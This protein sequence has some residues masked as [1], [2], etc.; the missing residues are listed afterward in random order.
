MYMTT[1]VTSFINVYKNNSD[2]DEEERT[3]AFRMEKLMDL[4]K[5]GINLCVY[6]DN[7]NVDKVKEKI[8]G[9]SNVKLLKTME[10]TDL[11]SFKVCSD[12]KGLKLPQTNNT[13]KDTKEYMML[14]NSKIEIIHDAIRQDT[15]NTKYFAWIDF[16]ISRI[17][18]STDYISV[19][20]KINDTN[21]DKEILTIPGCRD[22]LSNETELCDVLRPE[23]NTICWRFCGGFFWGD[24][25][26]L[27][28][29]YDKYIEYFPKFV[30]K[31]KMIVWE[32]NFWAWLECNSSWSPKWYLGDHNDTI[33]EIPSTLT[34]VSVYSKSKSKVYDYPLLDNGIYV[35][36]SASYIRHNGKHILNTRYVNYTI[37]K[38]EYT[39]RDG[40]SK[41][42]TRNVVSYLNDELIP[43]NYI[44]IDDP[45]K[46]Q[47]E[48]MVFNGIEDIRLYRK[49]DIIH[50]I[51]T[52]LSHSSSGNNSMVT[53]IYNYLDFKMENCRSITSPYNNYCEKN[54][55]PM[56]WKNF[57]IVVYK[58]YP[59]EIFKVIRNSEK[60]ED[61]LEETITHRVKNTIFRNFRGSSLFTMIGNNLLGLVHFSE[62]EYIRRRYFH[63]L[64]L[65]DGENMKPIRYSDSFY[66]DKEVGIEFCTGFAIID[67]KYQFWVSFC[68]RSPRN[69]SINID[70][71]PLCNEVFYE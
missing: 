37:E 24:K 43:T 19:L 31:Y 41:I 4:V 7:A 57:E 50:F 18:T 17:F 71:I 52:S 63:V 23:L 35:P 59:M 22:K 34:A 32:V 51:G 55:T 21:C 38:N 6:V 36:G 9:Y 67:M 33:I 48:L 69:I 42:I 53:G 49:N 64:V 60:V 3:I 70:S 15:F 2:D 5:S 8:S 46:V 44:E 1:F 14:M 58:W 27:E 28:D 47:E 56:I 54:W 65:L 25:S 39:F 16:S 12:I 10:L 20:K 13:I 30:M 29:F 68:D 26:S 62:G 66:F 11:F 40:G 61:H 45:K